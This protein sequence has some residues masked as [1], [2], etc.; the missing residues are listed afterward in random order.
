MRFLILILLL[1]KGI[2]LFAVNHDT[3]TA[4]HTAASAGRGSSR[5]VPPSTKLHTAG[6]A[7]D[8]ADLFTY[9]QDVV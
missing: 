8:P 1:D 7:E 5:L 2:D 3:Y 4:P 9:T 6:A